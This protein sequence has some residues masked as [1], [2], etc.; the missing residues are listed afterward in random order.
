LKQQ[1][2]ALA[3]EVADR[4]ER[5]HR[6]GLTSWLEASGPRLQADRLAVEVEQVETEQAETRSALEKL[7]Y[8]KAARAASYTE[9]QRSVREENAR[10]Q[11]RKGMLDRET[12]GDSNE[13]AVDAPCTGTVLTL[14][15]QA[16]GAVVHESDV[17]AEVVCAGARLQAELQL[18][19][20]GLAL[21]G[22]G[23]PVKLMYDAF[24]YQRY[25]VRYGTVRWVSPASDATADAASFRVFADLE[26]SA[27]RIQGESRA[28]APGMGGR[29]AII[30]GRRSLVSY[31]FE[32][33]RQ[34]REN[35][36]AR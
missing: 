36:S 1:Q 4:H 31:A 21:V 15:V 18:P 29:A 16:A 7:R 9:L 27:V 34:M 30:V 6:E 3:R 12:G 26:E 28:L 22:P 19:Q 32:P 33:I 17:L 25:G 8:E 14:H 35:L 24:P 11:A 23:Q 20:R 2:L 5:S 10:A 13:M